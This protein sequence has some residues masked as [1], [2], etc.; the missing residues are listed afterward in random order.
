VCAK[1]VFL[2]WSRIF[3]LA[4]PE[5]PASGGGSGFPFIHISNSE[6]PQRDAATRVGGGGGV[7]AACA[8]DGGLEEG[9]LLE[10]VGPGRQRDGG[11][12]GGLSAG[13]NARLTLEIG[14][15]AGGSGGGGAGGRAGGAGG[16]REPA[17]AGEAKPAVPVLTE[18][19]KAKVEAEKKKAEEVKARRAAALSLLLEPPSPGTFASISSMD[20]ASSKLSPSAK[21][22]D[23]NGD[24]LGGLAGL[25]PLYASQNDELSRWCG[26]LA[27]DG[28]GCWWKC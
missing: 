1:M 9:M 28:R 12:S 6:T 13:T 4:A 3:G 23:A 16:L 26:W 18:E 14:V 15:E 22:T 25:S 8:E 21:D 11:I 2:Q 10:A 27:L 20:G 19:E 17:R 5:Q 7:N 24:G